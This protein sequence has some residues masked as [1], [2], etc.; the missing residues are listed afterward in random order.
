MYLKLR[1]ELKSVDTKSDLLQLIA[2]LMSYPKSKKFKP[3]RYNSSSGKII[4]GEWEFDADSYIHKITY[5]PEYGEILGVR[6]HGKMQRR[7]NHFIENNNTGRPIVF[8]VEPT[9]DEIDYP[10]A[11]ILAVEQICTGGGHNDITTYSTGLVIQA[12]KEIKS[13]WG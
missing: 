9:N 11:L 12:V 1:Q 10:E 5:I 13:A 7:L 4:S 3:T 8:T 6:L 2:D